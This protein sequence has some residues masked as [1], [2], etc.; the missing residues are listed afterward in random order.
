MGPGFVLKRV[1]I[2]GGAACVS[3]SLLGQEDEA[4]LRAQYQRLA[5][6]IAQAE[7]DLRQGRFAEARKAAEAC[8]A[9]VPD[10]FQ[11]RF[12]LARLAYEAKD[13]DAALEHLRVSEGALAGWIARAKAQE[14]DLMLD[15]PADGSLWSATTEPASCS[16]RG[17]RA[18]ERAWRNVEGNPFEGGG[19]GLPEA[20]PAAHHLLHGNTLLRLGRLAEAEQP[21][22]RALQ[23]EPGNRS[24]WTNL[25]IALKGQGK[26][27]EALA[28]VRAAEARG[29]VLDAGLRKQVA[30]GR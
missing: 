1:W 19:N 9:Q 29:I 23:V 4:A 21:Y 7:R 2:L 12:L 27:D 28:Q 16:T 13:Y 18:K 22:R 6:R 8:A 26:V 20:I 30:A 14:A 10:H 17:Q 25:I 11:A 3:L 24:A 5:P 15:E